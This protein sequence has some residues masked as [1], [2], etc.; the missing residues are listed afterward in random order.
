L[1]A[2]PFSPKYSLIAEL[3][4]N[5]T[6]FGQIPCVNQGRE[7]TWPALQCT[8]E[9]HAGVVGSVGFSPDGK[10]IVSGSWDNTV[11]IWDA[12]TGQPVCEP[13][14][15][16]SKGVSS[17]GFS[18]D[19]KHIVS[20]SE[21]KTVRIWGADTGQPICEPLCGHSNSVTSVG[22]SPDRKHI[23]SGSCDNTVRIWDAENGQSSLDSSCGWTDEMAST[24]FTTHMVSGLKSNMA[25]SDNL[26][27]RKGTCNLPTVMSAT[28]AYL[29]MS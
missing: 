15:G 28:L 21:D 1:S 22:F 29:A 26:L 3:F 14:C 9:G 12:D 16:H 8:I 4:D 23:V 24:D 11:R 5:K 7:S 19:G 6:T 10:H 27:V 13:L 18:P 20:G 25:Q 17:V 2:L